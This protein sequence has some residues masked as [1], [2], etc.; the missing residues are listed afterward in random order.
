MEENER[1]TLVAE[2]KKECI[3]HCRFSLFVLA[4]R[5]LRAY[6]IKRVY[7]FFFC[8]IFYFLCDFEWFSP[9]YSL[10]SILLIVTFLRIVSTSRCVR[11]RFECIVALAAWKVVQFRRD[12]GVPKF[13]D[14]G[15]CVGNSKCFVEGRVFAGV[16]MSNLL[17][18]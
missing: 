15:R 5:W 3:L 18:M 9:Y 12:L 14:W 11:V 2:K 16:G 13:H 4:T 17:R 6:K 1:A 7:F 8:I 10:Y